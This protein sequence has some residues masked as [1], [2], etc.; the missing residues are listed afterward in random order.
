V[1]VVDNAVQGQIEEHR[2]DIANHRAFYRKAG[3]GPPVVLVHGGASDSG[4]WLKTM[5]ALAGRYTLYA[6]D[7]IGYG[8]SGRKEEG[9]YLSDFSDFLLEFVEALQI[10][11]PVLVGHSFGAR[12]CLEAALEDQER[13]KKLVLIDA[14]GFGRITWSGSWLMTLFWALRRLMR[15]PQP[16]P[17]FLTREGET[18]AWLCT[19]ELHRL[20]LPTLLVWKRFDPYM[21]LS[22]GRLAEK[23]IPGARLVVIPGFGHAPHKKDPETFNRLLL[24]FLERR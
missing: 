24:E 9:Y 20:N 5:A 17:R 3:T 2:L 8:Q 13:F 22:Q 19:D 6:P 1:S 4:D 21:P 7:L 10:E 18:T 12:V 11:N 14:A 16:Y 23:L 15:K